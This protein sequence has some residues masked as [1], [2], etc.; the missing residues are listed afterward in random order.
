MRYNSDAMNF[1]MSIE[2]FNGPYAASLWAD[3]HADLLIESALTAG[4]LDWD[5][6]RT[7]WGVAFEVAFKDEA[8][9]DAY[10]ESDAFR[11]AMATAPSPVDGVLI[12]RG[13]SLDGGSTNPRTKKPK[14]GSG[15]GALELPKAEAIFE[16]FP[17]FYSDGLTDRRQLVTS[18]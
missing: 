10:R 3:A 18:R 4:A 16:V 5:V 14:K 9:W 7:A 15:A 1:W 8:A 17:A 11:T 6:K 2:V 13:R 12:Y